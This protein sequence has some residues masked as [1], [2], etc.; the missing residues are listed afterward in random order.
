MPVVSRWSNHLEY[1]GLHELGMAVLFAAGYST[2]RVGE[3]NRKVLV[4]LEARGGYQTNKTITT[5]IAG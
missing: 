5:G 3:V 4:V 1:K 2:A